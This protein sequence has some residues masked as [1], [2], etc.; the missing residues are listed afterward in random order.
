MPGWVATAAGAAG[1]GAA[2]RRPGRRRS[3]PPA[4]APP[5][6]PRAAR[7]CRG[8]RPAD[9]R[10][11]WRPGWSAPTRPGP[12]P[13][14]GVVSALVVPDAVPVWARRLA[15]R[16]HSTAAG[17]AG[18]GA[19]AASRA[20]SARRPPTAGRRASGVPGWRR[21]SPAS[22]GRRPA[23]GRRSAIANRP[24]APHTPGHQ[25]RRLGSRD[26]PPLP[27]AAAAVG[28]PHRAGR[29]R[30]RVGQ[31][32]AA[33]GRGPSRPTHPRSAPPPGGRRGSRG[34][35]PHGMP[36]PAG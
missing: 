26:R 35:P 8:V 25:W 12:M 9:R 10:L 30:G 20:G 5:W 15:A 11:G 33:R 29:R 21:R 4:T 34:P 1:G 6:S 23:R 7:R 2:R 22:G 19:G 14:L 17:R 3:R 31:R 28:W 18:V 27:M 13:M 32:P 36:R 24:P 16:A